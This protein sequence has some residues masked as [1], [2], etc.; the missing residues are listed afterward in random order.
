MIRTLHDEHI[1]FMIST[2]SNPR[3]V[4]G[5]AL[6]A[7]HLQI[8]NGHDYIEL[9]NPAARAMRWEY[10]QKAFF[11]IGTD[12]WWQDCTEPN[13]WSDIM[14]DRQ[15][16]SGSSNRVRNA[17]ALFASQSTYEGQRSQ[18]PSK[19]VVILTR[20]AFPGI[21][22]YGT[23]C[24]SGDIF[25]DWQT[26]R[27]QVT[28]GLSF[29][30]CGI[31]YWTTDTGGFFR[32]KDQF[33]S[34]DY[35]ELL[36]RWFAWSTFC[37]ILRIHGGDTATEMWKWPMAEKTLK[38]FDALRYRMLPYNYSVAWMTTSGGYTPMRA[39]PFDFPADGKAA[40]IDDEFMSGPALLV[41]PV[42]QPHETPATPAPAGQGV[43]QRPV[44]L[45]SGAGWIDFWTGKS[46][47]GGQTVLA[48]APIDRIPLHV[49][50]GS[51]LPLGPACDYAGEHPAGPIE[52]RVYPGSDGAF[53]LYEDEGDN[54]NYEKGV[55]AVIPIM[56]NQREQSL[57]I[58]R[59]RGN[60]PG[61]IQSRAFHIVLVRPAHG[62]GADETA[63]ADREI[64]Y[65][66]DPIT[67]SLK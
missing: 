49:R 33:S 15:F 2:W 16:F 67:V 55:Y 48:D 65:N 53:N 59:R 61:M 34:P 3:G 7:A 31:P 62:V 43:Q 37:P 14:E 66:G 21:Q 40:T 29:S 24:W 57:T 25:G 38:F 54:Y 41:S 64:T 27:A 19:R 52:L 12:G 42:T 28:N 50:A 44:Y 58:D 5:D 63:D 20:S 9:T 56:W 10:V 6:A 13:D 60:Y 8:E 17:Y 39:L 45:P 51:I 46:L 47:A 4:A 18:D 1:H 35:N 26:F 11:S 23:G 32:P 30:L 36:Q 22:R